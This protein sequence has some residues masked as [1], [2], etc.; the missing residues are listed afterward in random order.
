LHFQAGVRNLQTYGSYTSMKFPHLRILLLIFLSV[1]LCPHGM[2]QLPLLTVEHD[3]SAGFIYGNGNGAVYAG[4][5]AGEN[6]NTVHGI[7]VHGKEVFGQYWILLG[8]MLL[9]RR[10]ATCTVTPAGVQRR[11]PMFNTVEDVLFADSLTLLSARVSTDWRGDVRILPAAA[12]EWHSADERLHA[13]ILVLVRDVQLRFD[14]VGLDGAWERVRPRDAAAVS[15]PAHHCIPAMYRG[16]TEGDFLFTVEVLHA[17]AA[18]TSRPLSEHARVSEQKEQRIASLLD[19][20]A[21]SCSDSS[22]TGTLQWMLASLHALPWATPQTEPNTGECC[23]GQSGRSTLLSLPGMMAAT[24]RSDEALRVINAFAQRIDTATGS[25]TYGRIPNR[26]RHDMLLRDAADITPW[27]ILSLWRY[28]EHSGD[29]AALRKLF[30]VVQVAI[31]GALRHTDSSGLLCHAPAETWMDAR[32][33]HGPWSARSNRAIE[34]QSLWL[35][36][37]RTS[38]R[39]ARVAKQHQ[40]AELWED[41]IASKVD[42]ALASLYV[43]ADTQELFDH[44]RED[45]TADPRIRPNALLAFTLPDGP[46][47]SFSS[48]TEA[49]TL[50][51][52]FSECVFP[53]GVTTLSSLDTDFRPVRDAAHR[54]PDKAA[55]HNGLI[56][57]W[58]TGAAVDALCRHGRTDMAWMLSSAM[59]GF[60]KESA[61]RGIIPDCVDALPHAAPS[62]ARQMPA[63]VQSPGNAEFF[64]V[65]YE[66]YLGVRVGYEAG[67]VMD[68]AP[69][70]PSSLHRLSANVHTAAG[71]VHVS[72]ER[73]D[74]ARLLC[75]FISRSAQPVLLRSAVQRSYWL[76]HKA[77]DDM[78]LPPHGRIDLY[79]DDA[80]P[81]GTAFAIQAGF[82]RMLHAQ[83]TGPTEAP[84]ERLLDESD[85]NASN[86]EALLLCS[87]MNPD[88]GEE[89]VSGAHELS[90]GRANRPGGFDLLSAEVRA[91]ERHLYFTVRL[92]MQFQQ[93]RYSVSGR[94]TAILAIAVDRRLPGITAPDATSAQ[95]C[96]PVLGHNSGYRFSGNFRATHSILVGN[97]ITVFDADG[98]LLAAYRP[99]PFAA[100]F[101]DAHHAGIQFA[102]PRSLFGSEEHPWRFVIVSGAREVARG[103]LERFRDQPRHETGAVDQEAANASANWYDDMD[104]MQLD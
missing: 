94:E 9:D 44:I 23:D 84:R 4:I 21:L 12:A 57:P 6:D 22:V 29:S 76:R 65:L 59:L 5:V 63:I 52:I 78:E 64:R 98:V 31:D 35:A 43:N 39:I 70:L 16:T 85:I 60:A 82:A 72:L 48:E 25:A 73:T 54:Y 37:L 96:T 27:M 104:C 99:H 24:G 95:R 77:F 100:G 1:A 71:I 2:A 41:V 56:W 83:P 10:S 26:R 55:C 90:T 38:A 18:M 88:D 20:A 62:P 15:L 8:D 66:R 50:Q 101:L 67:P 32:G 40:L 30:P 58:L 68:F 28:F 36:Q 47:A 69:H 33:M 91:D 61:V 81:A 89:G 92:R 93:D 97:G 46:A 87:S 11:Y 42:R 53:R 19:T 49:A 75:T 86:D 80:T 3:K 14:V 103:R 45:G 51:R 74:S 17:D 79:H 13:D 7:T 102:L 34:V